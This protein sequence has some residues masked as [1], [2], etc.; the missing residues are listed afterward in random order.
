MSFKCFDKVLKSYITP[1]SVVF[2]KNKKLKPHFS[3]F[4]CILLTIDNNNNPPKKPS[5]L[6]NFVG[7]LWVGINCLQLDCKDIAR[8]LKNWM[9]HGIPELGDVG[10]LGLGRTTGAVLHQKNYEDDPH[11]VSMQL[12]FRYLW[13]QRY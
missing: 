11:A 4:G 12:F 2:D 1:K 13:S 6:I 7:K 10:G 9:T 8:R 5:K 3:S